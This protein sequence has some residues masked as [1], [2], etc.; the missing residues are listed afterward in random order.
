MPK[1]RLGA[2]PELGVPSE[3]WN[4]SVT[5]RNESVVL[6]SWKRPIL[7]HGEITK[8]DIVFR[9]PNSSETLLEVAGYRTSY[10]LSFDFQHN[11][12]YLFWVSTLSV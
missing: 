10:E 12:T 2:Y 7:P 1:R 6:V 3:P 5:Q 4:I 11:V 9:A 8:Y